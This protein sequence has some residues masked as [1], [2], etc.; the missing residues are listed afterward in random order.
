MSDTETPDPNEI[1]SITREDA[2][3]FHK[4]YEVTFATREELNNRWDDVQNLHKRIKKMEKRINTE[5]GFI[6]L[7]FLVLHWLN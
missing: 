4:A 5:L 3:K 7:V 6:C 2:R 1:I